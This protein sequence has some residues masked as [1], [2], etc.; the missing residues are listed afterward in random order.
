MD[1]TLILPDRH[2]KEN[3]EIKCTS[4]INDLNRTKLTCAMND[5]KLVHVGCLPARST[6]CHVLTQNNKYLI[7][8][9]ML[10]FSKIVHDQIH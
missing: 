8:I 6:V 2:I 1:H 5:V 7:I 10:Y 3:C 9:T 4:M